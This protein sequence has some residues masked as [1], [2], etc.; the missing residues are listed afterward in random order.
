MIRFPAVDAFRGGEGLIRVIG[1]R[2]ARGLVPE[3]SM[4]GFE[5][6]MSSGVPLLEFDVVMTADNVPVITHNHR[7]HAPTFRDHS[8]HFLT[9]EPKIAHLTWA[10]LQDYDIGRIDGASVY[11]QRFP[12]QAQIDGI[13]VP[14]LRELLQV[15]SQDRFSSAHL[16]LEIKSD[17]AFA[18][19]IEYRRLLVRQVVAEVHASGLETRT[20]L[21][22]FDWSLLTECQHQAPE[23][24]T[25]FLTQLPENEEDIG[26]D[27]IMCI[28]PDFS[29][30]QESIPELVVNAGGRLWCPYL[31][32]VTCENV[33]K[34]H[35]L[36]LIVAVWT[37]NE[38][39]DIHRMIDLGVD[40]IVSDYPGRVQRCLADQGISWLVP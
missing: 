11:G 26:E 25:S 32:D 27:S 4:L 34:A 12:D 5:F 17:P 20:L 37:V 30:Q 9:T 29:G 15:T 24:P 13:R 1:H 36:G 10:Q 16:M 39:S 23:M 38:P 3:N 7:L 8:G 2:G 35:A 19:D 28:S 14:S 40:A 18:H 33:A 31:N 21:H 22:S 6:A